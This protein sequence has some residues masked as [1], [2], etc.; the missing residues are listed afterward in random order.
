MVFLPIY[1]AQCWIVVRPNQ[2]VLVHSF[3]KVRKV[4]KTPGCHYNP[5]LQFDY[6]SSRV[7]TLQINGSSVPDLKGSPM[8]VSVI[9]NFQ[10]FDPIRAMYAVD[11]YKGYLYN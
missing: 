8:H 5:L 2:M 3:G 4:I 11:D 10:I 9:V 1:L 7:E 6:I